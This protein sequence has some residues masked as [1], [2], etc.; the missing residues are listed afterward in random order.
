MPKRNKL[1]A[2]PD[3]VGSGKNL[4]KL[5]IQKS[6][7]LL[8]LSETSITLPELKILD[9]Y[10]SRIN[11]HEPKKRYVQL[12]KGELE[13]MLGVTRILQKDLDARINNL[14]QVVTVKDETKRNGFT[15]V[16]LFEKVTCE[17]NEDGLWQ[18]DLMCTQSAM[19]YIFNIENLGY[20]KYRLRNVVN[21]TSR[22]SY[23]LYLYLEDNIYR[24]TWRVSLDELKQMLNCTAETYS[25]YKRFNDLILKKCQ[26][27]IA[28]KTDISFTYTTV[29][30]GRKVVAISFE[31][32][33]VARIE[34]TVEP[35]TPAELPPEPPAE[36]LKYNGYE[37]EEMM[38]FGDACLY[39]FNNSQIKELR[40]IIVEIDVP[41]NGAYFL[42]DE[43]PFGFTDLRVFDEFNFLCMEYMKMKRYT[44]D[45]GFNSKRRF[46]YLIKTL[47]NYRAV[48]LR[49]PMY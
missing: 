26:K 38:M 28:E 10:L 9:V 39:E 1:P 45:K 33:R 22:Y 12:E 11:S 5:T 8:T 31:V 4:E 25:E 3:Y 2:V 48:H 27:E 30:K 14:F 43:L 41:E 6:N 47:K 24:K 37:S 20:L 35:P 42:G 29:K 49:V 40:S 21:L 15:K 17:Q 13:K 18:I 7:P 16:S 36:E 44:K 23:I 32:E 34:T 46:A 19:E